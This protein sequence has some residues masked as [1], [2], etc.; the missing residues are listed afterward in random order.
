MLR[1]GDACSG[2]TGR[3]EQHRFKPRHCGPPPPCQRQ[4][5]MQRH[6]R[7]LSGSTAGLGHLHKPGKPGLGRL[8]WK[9]ASL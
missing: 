8:P 5:P 7:Q 1:A 3:E 4:H 2:H 9:Y 6:L